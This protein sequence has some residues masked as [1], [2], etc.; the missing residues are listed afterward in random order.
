MKLFTVLFLSLSTPFAQAGIPKSCYQ[1]TNYPTCVECANDLHGRGGYQ[2]DAEVLASVLR[3]CASQY[4]PKDIQ[5][6]LEHNNG[7]FRRRGNW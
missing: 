6:D 3:Q 4:R 2:E 1:V 5:P 7:N